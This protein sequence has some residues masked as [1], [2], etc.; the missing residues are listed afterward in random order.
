MATKSGIKAGDRVKVG[1]G[2]KKMYGKDMD[3]LNKG[4]K[5]LCIDPESESKMTGETE[6]LWTVIESTITRVTR[7]TGIRT[8]ETSHNYLRSDGVW[9]N[10]NDEN[11]HLSMDLGKWDRG[12]ED[13]VQ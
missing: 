12:F 10:E 4:D 8:E 11:F 1:L 2:G 7:F 9:S 6:L 3:D 5:V 13:G